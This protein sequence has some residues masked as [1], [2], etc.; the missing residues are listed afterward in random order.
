M[1]P[2]SPAWMALLLLILGCQ[3]VP[4]TETEVRAKLLGNYCDEEQVFRLEVKDDSTYFHRKAQKGILTT[5]SLSYESCN[6]TY[7]L[8][9]EGEVWKLH[10][11]PDDRPRN[12]LFKNCERV[13]D[14]WNPEEGY[15]IG[16]ATVH[17]PDLFDNTTLTKNICE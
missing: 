2:P 7:E 10:F 5:R 11:L 14:V 6:G 12:S 4:P 1:T 3:P 13:V 9:L 8:L 15:L 16:E 17:L